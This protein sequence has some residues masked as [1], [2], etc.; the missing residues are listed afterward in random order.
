MYRGD[1]MRRTEP[2]KNKKTD[3]VMKRNL[4]SYFAGR[5]ALCLAT[6]CLTLL[7]AG[8]AD[9]G[10][11]PCTADGATASATLHMSVAGAVGTRAGEE[12]GSVGL[13]NRINTLRVLVVVDG[14]RIVINHKLSPEELAAQTVTIGNI[15]VGKVTFRVL[16]NEAALGKDYDTDDFDLVDVPDRTSKKALLIDTER[17]YFPKRFP[18]VN[19][20]EGLPMSWISRE[21]EVTA[22]QPIGTPEEPVEVELVR[23]VAKLN[24]IMEN[25]LTGTNGSGITITGMTFGGFFGDRLY[26]FGEGALDVPGATAY[27]TRTYEGLNIQIPG[28]EEKTLACYIY[29]SYAWKPEMTG[30]PYTIGFSTARRGEYPAKPFISGEGGALNSI[31]RNTQVNIRATLSV[32][33]SLTLSYEVMEWGEQP[34]TVPPFN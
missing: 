2:T 26:L 14:D 31:A 19:S 15:P 4:K 34:I 27:D 29:P 17:T 13:E 33:A 18:D 20:E 16:A 8:C 1:R 3:E 7:M 24:I 12:D 23:C 25:D 28:G 11:A 10:A 22:G 9:D 30:S 5:L 21:I 32:D 6:A